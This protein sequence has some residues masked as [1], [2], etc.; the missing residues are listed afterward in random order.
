MT[1]EKKAAIDESLKQWYEAD[2]TREETLEEIVSGRSGVSLRV[3]DWF[4][5]NYSAR[6]P[7]IYDRGGQVVE[8]NADYK[9]ALRCFHKVAFDSFK[10][11]GEAE[12]RQRNFFRWAIEKGVVEYVLEHRD[13]IEKDMTEMKKGK[14]PRP[15]IAKA[16][17][18]KKTV[19]RPGGSLLVQYKQLEW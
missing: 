13:E 16:Q 5:T 1:P 9:E 2:A 10:R 3:I 19:L 15:K 17:G 18:K 6:N 4:V 11:R 14:K 7:V 8:V 12:L